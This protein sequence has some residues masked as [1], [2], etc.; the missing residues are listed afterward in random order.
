MC[1]YLAVHVLAVRYLQEVKLST[2][3]YNLTAS[4][5]LVDS[6]EFA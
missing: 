3:Y 4:E 1:T 2:L 6:N 5:H